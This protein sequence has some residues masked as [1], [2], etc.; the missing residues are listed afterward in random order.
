M[1]IWNFTPEYSLNLTLAADARLGRTDYTNDQIWQLVLGGSQPPALSLETTFGLRARQCRI[2]PR[3]IYHDQVINDPDHFSHP[4]VI[5]QYYPNYLC[6]SFKPFSSINVRL[7]YWVPTSQVIACRTHITNTGHETCMLELEWAELL[8]P[9]QGGARMTASEFG[10]STILSGRTADL[11]PVLFLSGGAQAGRSPY[12]CLNLAYSLAPKEEQVVHWVHAA[13]PELPASY[14]QAKQFINKNW[15]AE[16]ARIVRLNSKQLEIFTGNKDWDNALHLSQNLAYQLV[17]GPTQLCKAP[18]AVITRKPDQG[19][20]ALQDGSDYNHL[21]NG[22]TALDAYYLSY[23]L[24]SSSPQLFKGMLDNFLEAHNSQGEIDWKPGLGGQRS[25]LPAT[26][27]LADLILRW[28]EYTA[29]T[30]YLTSAYPK[31]LASF[32]TWFSDKHDRDGD[33]VPE[34]DQ[35]AQTG[36]DDLPLFSQQLS[37]SK[38]VDIACVESPDLIAYLYRESQALLKIGMLIDRH[39]EN[40]KLEI[41]AAQLKTTCETMWNEQKACYLYRD[42]DSHLS[43]TGETLGNRHGAGVIDVQRDFPTPVRP[44]ILIRTER[45]LTRPAQI[46][47]H[48]N[49]ASGAHKVENIPTTRIRW[50]ANRGFVTSDYC[51]SSIERIE[52]NG[53]RSDDEVIAETVDLE[54][55][56]QSQLFPLWAGIPSAERA[57]IL[58]NLTIM[59]K[60]KFLGPF[61]LRTCID[62]P[63]TSRFPQDFYGSH[64][65]WTS[66][67]LEGLVHYGERKKA[68]VVFTRLMKP[69]IQAFGKEMAFYQSYHSESGKA[70]GTKN[71]LS[72]LIPVGLFLLIL[73]VKIYSPTR[74]EL[75]G[76]NPFPW[77]VT[78]KYQ[79]LTVVRHEK[80]TLVIF[81]NA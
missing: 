19:F 47:I 26:P 2:F 14:D 12:P 5:H 39:E 7:E 51:F 18:S 49:S 54:S 48:G 62:F 71:A 76:Y 8:L 1:Q 27:L 24:L 21:W 69:A 28:Y 4:V 36:F 13:L 32:L 66:L 45:E 55:M 72:S 30:D 37:W 16:I 59:N 46:F 3:F 63:G 20:S 80:K 79:G 23:F 57:K 41:I 60:K 25:H 50:Q 73:G 29:Q 68:A 11:F 74:V 17:V 77:P 38:G 9:D 44:Y 53:L 65:P 67:V 75:S 6:L 64:L 70:S 33:Q 35:D 10:M 22:L 56:D 61:G 31:L 43:P 42:R 34:W 15:E 52:V 58:T 78:L 40:D 81:P